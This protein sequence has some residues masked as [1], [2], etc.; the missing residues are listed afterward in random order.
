VKRELGFSDRAFDDFARPIETRRNAPW[1]QKTKNV[2]GVELVVRI[3]SADPGY[4]GKSA[5]SRPAT[6]DEIRDGKFYASL[7]EFRADRAA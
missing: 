5:A 7:E 2:D 1:L 4:D 3:I 6:P